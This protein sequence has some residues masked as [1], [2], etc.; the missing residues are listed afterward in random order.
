MSIYCIGGGYIINGRL[1]QKTVNTNVV[2]VQV[3]Q[4]LNIN[5]DW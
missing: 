1:Y 3:V 2:G 4:L 5:L